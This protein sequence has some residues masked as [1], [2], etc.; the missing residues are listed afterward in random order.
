MKRQPNTPISTQRFYGS[1]SMNIPVP[2]TVMLIC[3]GLL[4]GLFV[5]Y[6]IVADFTQWYV[7]KGY[8]NAKSGMVRVYPLRQGVIKR[9]LVK[10][11]Q[12]VKKGEVLYTVDTTQHDHVSHPTT[13]HLLQKRL[14]YFEQHLK[15]KQMYLQ[16]IKPLLQK[17]YVS[18]L[19]Y[20]SQQDQI[21]ALES[22]RHEAQM[23]LLRYQQSRI[24]VVRAPITGVISS[25]E[26][27]KG[28]TI[29]H[30]K[31][32]LTI[33]PSH[34]ELIAQLYVPVS[35]SG[36][37]NPSE[38]IVLRYDAY[39]Y[40]HFGVAKAHIVSIT[41]SVLSDHE[42]D[43]PIHIGEP[44]YK[45]MAQLDKQFI[46]L[47]GHSHALKQ[48]MTCSALIPGAHK[49]LW[50]WMFDPFYRYSGGGAA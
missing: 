20:Q 39:P 29:D 44:Y 36:F 35:K 34:T 14:Q 45:V 15:T 46:F 25:L 6:S 5:I 49:K 43:K 42:E 3:I 30:T 23:A 1:V 40:Q 8:L 47:Y 48:G 26:F 37:L 12:H 31:S 4:F 9:C 33:L 28:Q 27:G 22:N 17:H 41:H 2:Y 38:S 10:E 13:Y 11:G 50:R 7:V 24:Y 21:N 18:F 32:L 16:T 19:T